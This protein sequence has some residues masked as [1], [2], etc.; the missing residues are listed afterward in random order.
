MKKLIVILF[1]L[2][3]LCGAAAGQQSNYPNSLDSRASLITVTNNS[4]S[5]LAAS[6]TAGALARASS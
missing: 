2:M 5:T 6:I 1:L 4:S 3:F